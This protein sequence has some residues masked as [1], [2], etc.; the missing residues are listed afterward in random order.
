MAGERL[1][2]GL[3]ELA[4]ERVDHRFKALPP[5]AEGRT[6]AELA[7]ERRNLFR[8]GFTTLSSPSPPSRSPTT[9]P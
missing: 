7:A 3:K 9:W 5:D 2:Q 8:D 1:A 6:V 4:D